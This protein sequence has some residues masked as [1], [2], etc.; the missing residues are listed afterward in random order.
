MLGYFLANNVSS[1]DYD[2]YLTDAGI[3]GVAER[4]ITALSVAGRNGDLL[5]DN[6]RY[7]NKTFSYP[8]II[9]NNFNTHFSAFINFLLSQKGYIRIEDSF[10]PEIFLMAR[11]IGETNPQKVVTYGKDGVFELT[12]DRKPQRFLKEGENPISVNTNEVIKN[13]YPTT[14]LPKI[15]AYGTGY[16]KINDIKITINTANQYTDIDCETQNAY[17]ED[18]NC[19]GKITLNDGEFFTLKP[20]LNDVEY[21]VSQVEIT[22]NWWIL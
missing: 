17:K 14:A 19:N 21:T 9:R 8:C 4:D 22:P 15:R 12:F 16:V 7:K 18:V 2:I 10:M 13:S 1:E 3:Y 11:Y 5:F 6:K 20:G